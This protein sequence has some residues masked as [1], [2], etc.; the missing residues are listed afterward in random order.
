MA[1]ISSI[2]KYQCMIKE[3]NRIIS[4]FTSSPGAKPRATTKIV[5][6]I[7]LYAPYILNGLTWEVKAKSLGAGVYELS[8]EQIRLED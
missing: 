7:L 2:V 6:H 3:R 5:R 4:I 1:S 8:I